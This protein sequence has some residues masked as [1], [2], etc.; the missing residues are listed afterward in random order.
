MIERTF[1]LIKSEPCGCD[2]ETHF[3]VDTYQEQ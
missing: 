1:K 3:W 2:D